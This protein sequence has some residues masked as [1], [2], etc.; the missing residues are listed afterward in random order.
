LWGLQTRMYNA[1]KKKSK[2]TTKK[3]KKA[4]TI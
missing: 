3:T 1:L 2:Q 4:W